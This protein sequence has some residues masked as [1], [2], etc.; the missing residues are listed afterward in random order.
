MENTTEKVLTYREYVKIQ[1]LLTKIKQDV[2]LLNNVKNE[3]YDNINEILIEIPHF[4]N[5]NIGEVDFLNDIINT[6]T[7]HIYSFKSV[8]VNYIF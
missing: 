1:N 7:S 3:V 4:S 5:S 8:M 6:N 2:S